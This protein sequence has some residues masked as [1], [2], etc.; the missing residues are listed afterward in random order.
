MDRTIVLVKT[1]KGIEE[2]QDRRYDL[3]QRLRSALVVV[4]GHQSVGTLLERFGEVSGVRVALAR[5]LDQGFVAV[6]NSE[7]VAE[8]ADGTPH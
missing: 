6:N 3:P 5:L 1:D 8:I 4:D 7:A 2:L